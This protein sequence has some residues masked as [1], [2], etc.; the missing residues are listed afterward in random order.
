MATTD[1][2]PLALST[3]DL[4]AADW[5]AII[6]NLDEAV[7]A[8]G[9]NNEILYVNAA[10]ERLLG[11]N[12]QDL[13]GSRLTTLIP[14]RFIAR[15]A[16]GFRRFA[17]GEGGALIGTPLRLPALRSDGTETLVELLI[18]AVP[19]AGVAAVGLLRNV[20]DRI[21]LEG[22]S[23]LSD[24]LVA[25][26]AESATLDE[27]WPRVLEALVEELR[28]DLAQ[29]WL[30]TQGGALQ[31]RTAWA[32][33]ESE[34]GGLITASNRTFALGDGLPGRVWEALEPIWLPE[35]GDV[36]EFPRAEAA[37]ACGL[38]SAF[39]FPLVAG[40]R[41]VGVVELFSVNR[42]DPNEYLTR[43]LRSLGG[44]LG[45]FVD[46]RSNEEQLLALAT[47]LQQSLL[48][49]H[50]PEI[51]GVALAA[52]YLPA[53]GGIE[54]GGD[55]YDVF[56]IARG[57]W[58]VA[59]GDVCGKGPEAASITA[60]ARYTIRAAAVVERSPAR[61][62][63]ALNDA[64]LRQA[65]D[66]GPDRFVT[67]VLAR[68]RPRSDSLEVTLACGGHPLPLVRRASGAVETVGRAGTVL[69]VQPKIKVHD[70]TAV[71]SPGDS[72]VMVTDG[73]LEARRD[74]V[75]FGGARLAALLAEGVFDSPKAIADA[76]T[77]AATDHQRGHAPDD[78]AVV[79]LAPSP[80]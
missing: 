19:M 7:V 58:G 10:L 59:I 43:R 21:E 23:D 31:R 70:T 54:V 50:P 37:F 24:R 78:I 16:E 36:R 25:T 44:E 52:R 55:F 49:P 42:R 3:R 6:D 41:F 67:A 17:A 39:A 13:L 5:R 61:A 26:M 33:P 40:D 60:L 32:A 72:L 47:T 28:W 48:P 75:Q 79:V 46:R 20:A 62:L 77:D 11:W 1:H 30:T 29:L 73:V 8:A 53:S 69:G 65:A 34:F 14:E 51:P 74:G 12:P 35:L 38:R 27:A 57:T 80:R 63:V 71:L 22:P 76:V 56:R 18:S 66:G 45:W 2:D 4:R 15:H 9:H 68:V 64:L